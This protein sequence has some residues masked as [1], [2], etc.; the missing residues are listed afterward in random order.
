[1]KTIKSLVF[2]LAVGGCVS[3][4]E[5]E[6]EERNALHAEL[7]R[8]SMTAKELG[9]E[10]VESTGGKAVRWRERLSPRQ[11]VT[12]PLLPP[13]SRF[14]SQPCTRGKLNGREITVSL[15]TGASFTAVGAED[16]LAANLKIANPKEFKNTFQGLAG[17]EENYYGLADTLELGE[18]K[19]Q[20]VFCVVRPEH[21]VSGTNRL[22][23]ILGLASLAKLN[24]FTI[25]YPSRTV[26]FCA[27]QPLPLIENPVAT[28]NFD[29]V[30][31]QM[32]T[33]MILNGVQVATIIDTGSD[34]PIMLPGRL[35]KEMGLSGRAEKGKPGRYMGIGGIVETRSFVIEEIRLGKH[36]FTNIEVVSGPDNFPPT[37][38]SDFLNEY[39][40]TVDVLKSRV[41]LS[42][43]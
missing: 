41:Y 17:A 27:D 32:R 28:I 15:D 33:D 18:L 23:N 13:E 4:P 24:W 25:D 38:G 29:F 43:N 10:I 42:Q 2:A 39:R 7:N 31:M 26:T 6:P 22:N 5:R 9:V 20:N 21:G 16:A 3:Q 1:V 35:V 34:A 30:A 11:P 14:S 8:R 37:I 36:Q 19:F 40:V 12:V